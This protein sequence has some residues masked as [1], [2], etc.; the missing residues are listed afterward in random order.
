MAKQINIA[1]MQR[2]VCKSGQ[3][4]NEAVKALIEAA[5]KDID[6]TGRGAM[7]D[8]YKMNVELVPKDTGRAARGFIVSEE[9]T[10]W[11]PPPGD[12]EGE[13]QSMTT[14]NQHTLDKIPPMS[15]IS[16]SNNIEYIVPLENGHST[17]A[18][19]GFWVLSL[20]VLTKRF[21]RAAEVYR[22]KKY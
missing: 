17:K 15:R 1:E 21:E 7:F 16:V 11:V 13:I 12:Y 10:E 4:F 3:E 8:F 18:P 5:A 22:N 20:Q 2:R 14:E 9:P 6:Q 19:A